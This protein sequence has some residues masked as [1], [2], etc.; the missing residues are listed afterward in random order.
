MGK[1]KGAHDLMMRKEDHGNEFRKRSYAPK[2]VEMGG[3]EPP[4]RMCQYQPVN[5]PEV[6]GILPLV[7]GHRQGSGLSLYYHSV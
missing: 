4:S 7:F 3:V 6:R 1:E 5:H 2:M